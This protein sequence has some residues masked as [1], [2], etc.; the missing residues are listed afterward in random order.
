MERK[1]TTEGISRVTGTEK[2]YK[3]QTQVSGHVPRGDVPSPPSHSA[4]KFGASVGEH[5]KLLNEGKIV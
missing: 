4:K 5:A 1:R 3:E 2:T